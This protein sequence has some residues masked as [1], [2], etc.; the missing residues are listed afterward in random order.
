MADP[1][2]VRCPVCRREHAYTP[3]AFPCPCGRPLTVPVLRGGIPTQVR[4][5]A[6]R[7]A[8]VTVRCGGCGR[9]GE[10]PRPEVTC[11]CGTVFRPPVDTVA[12]DGLPS[13]AGGAPPAGVPRAVRRPAFEPRPVR[14]GPE[15]V[16]AAAA[17][18]RWLGFASVDADRDSAVTGVDVRGAGVRARVDASGAP[19]P[20][21]AVETLWLA[22]LHE[23][24]VAALFSLGGFEDGTLAAARRLDVP[25]FAL[26]PAG[27]A[28][29]VNAAAER[30]LRTVPGPGG[31]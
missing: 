8:W 4:Q 19:V 9:S 17:Y 5:R 6:W 21:A 14:G 27:H 29:P 15:A 10:W 26:S 28:T 13:A 16:V 18:L 25:L 1:V 12:V 11:G 20:V 31:R 30:L 7:D 22:C 2:P 23:D 24:A 3:A